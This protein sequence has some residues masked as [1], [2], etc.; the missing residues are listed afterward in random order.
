MADTLNKRF[1]NCM[2]Y[3][4]IVVLKRVVLEYFLEYS[5]TFVAKYLRGSVEPIHGCLYHFL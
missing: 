3:K 1:T 5:T 4:V 2:Y